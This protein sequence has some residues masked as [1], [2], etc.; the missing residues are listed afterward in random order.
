LS[1]IKNLALFSAKNTPLVMY[2]IV[3]CIVAIR[4]PFYHPD[5]FA[6]LEMSL[7][8][9]PVYV[10]FLKSFNLIFGDH[11]VWPVI[12]VQFLA[13]VCAT[14]YLLNILEKQFHLNTIEK[15]LL[16]FILIS[17]SIYFNYT[18][19]AILSE[20][21]SHPL[22]LIVFA[23][24]FKAFATVNLKPLL[25]SIIPLYFLIMTRGQFVV[26]VPVFIALGIYINYQ[27]NVDPKKWIPVLLLI[28]VPIFTNYSERLYNKLMFGYFESNTMNYV[29]LI[30]T[31]FYLSEPS[32]VALFKDPNEIEYFKI[33]HQSLEK[34]GL[35]KQSA[36]ARKELDV[37]VFNDNFS[38]IC[39]QRIQGLG[40]VYFKEKGLNYFEQNKALNR[41]CK[42][43]FFKMVTSNFKNRM[44]FFVKNLKITYGSAKYLLLFVLL[45]F[46]SLLKVHKTKSTLF[47][48]ILLSSVL[49]LANNMIIAFI[50]H[51]IKR[52]TFYFD[53]ILFAIM[54][55]V[56]SELS[57]KNR[58]EN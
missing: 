39:N 21:L 18:T 16:Q 27:K 20:A 12:T 30:S 5:S 54:I 51:A 4:G 49:M 42:G 26:I 36:E 9:S 55:L 47:K 56:F 23:L 35:T 45:I 32:T 44:Y 6:F 33:V 40:L 17:P 25:K 22:I 37:T 48:F 15:L 50:I 31:D 14:H 52:Y 28:I 24:G 19:G 2:L 46:Y 1:K 10:L 13:L 57:K 43:M 8:R 41:L 53:W 58:Y 7:N 29:H 38:K 34:A 3:G 11:Y